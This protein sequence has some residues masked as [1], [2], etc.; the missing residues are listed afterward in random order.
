M[1]DNLVSNMHNCTTKPPA[2]Y[3]KSL[4]WR[5]WW[6]QKEQQGFCEHHLDLSYCQR[7]FCQE[8]IL[9][10]VSLLLLFTSQSPESVPFSLR[11]IT[12]SCFRRWEWRECDGGCLFLWVGASHVH[13]C[14]PVINISK[15]RFGKET[16]ISVCVQF[17]KI[18][19][20]V[21]CGGILYQCL[22][23]H[24]YFGLI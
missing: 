3:L 22:H 10:T 4:D 8:Q 17:Y 20:E 9:L 24:V 11:T 5:V 15:G 7:F 1:I 14:L 16:V 21:V 23:V 19:E 2:S 18:S 13:E 12:L 6:L